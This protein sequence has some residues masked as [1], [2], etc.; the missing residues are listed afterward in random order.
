[1]NIKKKGGTK[2]DVR[3]QNPEPLNAEP[4]RQKSEVSSGVRFQVSEG[5][6]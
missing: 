4:R 2:S 5:R 3:V 6:G 1:M